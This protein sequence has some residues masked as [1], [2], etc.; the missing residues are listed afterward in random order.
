MDE[1]RLVRA[2]EAVEEG[3]ADL[4]HVA[5]AR[6]RLGAEGREGDVA[7]STALGVYPK[8]ARTPAS[9]ASAASLGSGS[10]ASGAPAP[11]RASSLASFPLGPSSSTRSRSTSE[12]VRSVSR[13]TNTSVGRS[14]HAARS[15]GAQLRAL[16]ARDLV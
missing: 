12:G 10:A 1:A 8:L 9:G 16:S 6:L 2:I 14:A 4:G 15:P 13:W 5:R 7:R 11:I 3:H